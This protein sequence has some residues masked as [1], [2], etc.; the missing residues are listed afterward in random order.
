MY[1][2]VLWCDLYDLTYKCRTKYYESFTCG[3]VNHV[4]RLTTNLFYSEES[5]AS[6]RHSASLL[7][8]CVH[9]KSLLT[10][11]SFQFPPPRDGTTCNTDTPLATKNRK[12]E[13]CARMPHVFEKRRAKQSKSSN[14]RPKR[15]AKQSSNQ[16]MAILKQKHG[17]GRAR[18][19]TTR[20]IAAAAAADC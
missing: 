8:H 4:V 11:V 14:G 1:E 18:C 3:S 13:G 2:Y 12:F 6:P 16:A 7:C 15:R 10:F 9:A 19:R 5:V 20:T 17:H